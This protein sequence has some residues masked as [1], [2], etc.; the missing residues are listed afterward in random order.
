MEGGGG[1]VG[2]EIIVEGAVEVCIIS[3]FLRCRPACS[4]RYQTIH[5]PPIAADVADVDQMLR[6]W[7]TSSAC[8]QRFPRSGNAYKD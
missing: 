7:G 1:K 6:G 5:Y 8:S 2:Y 4:D 3:G